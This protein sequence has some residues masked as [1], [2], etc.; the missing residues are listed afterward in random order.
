MIDSKNACPHQSNNN[1]KNR[2]KHMYP[3]LVHK[4]DIT[5]FL[6][7][8]IFYKKESVYDKK[9]SH[10]FVFLVIF[11]NKTQA[12]DKLLWKAK[13]LHGNA[14]RSSFLVSPRLQ[15]CNLPR[16]SKQSC[17]GSRKVA[18]RNLKRFKTERALKR[19]YGLPF[20][21]LRPKKRRFSVDSYGKKYVF[22]TTCQR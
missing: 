9:S 12:V 13:I 21:A 11:L 2:C 1:N 19:L 20:P 8:K 14:V 16:H 4:I 15:S 22:N 7:C 17:R 5:T 6:L 3:P 10:F 18:F